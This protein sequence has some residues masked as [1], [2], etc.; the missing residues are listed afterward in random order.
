MHATEISRAKEIITLHQNLGHP[1]DHILKEALRDRI[2][3]GVMLSPKD[4]DNARKLFGKCPAC[5]QGN[6][7]EP[8]H[9]ASKIFQTD[10]PGEILYADLKKT[11]VTC[12][13]GHTQMLIMRDYY[14]GYITVTGMK[15]KS[16]VS[17]VK[18]CNSVML[19][20]SSHG[21]RTKRLVFDHEAVFVAV[22]GKIPS[23]VCT[24]TPAGLHNR[25][26]ERAIQELGIRKL[27]A[28]CALPYVLDKRLEVC[29]YGNAA[30]S[31]N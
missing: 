24:Y 16:T 6:M 29:G 5:L 4:V 9:D 11:T 3:Q 14:S 1:S 21:H 30:R 31:S 12:F 23:V 13:E 28:E 8:N 22:Q 27:S 26:V 18:A 7:R 19:F 17:I 15:D 2:Y 25:L 10:V 20:Y